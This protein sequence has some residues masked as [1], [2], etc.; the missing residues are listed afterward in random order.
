[1]S[2]GRGLPPH[3]M[4]ALLTS[5]LLKQNEVTMSK[6]HEKKINLRIAEK[7]GNEDDKK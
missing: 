5:L 3:C 4:S 1:M 7:F 6:L 2:G